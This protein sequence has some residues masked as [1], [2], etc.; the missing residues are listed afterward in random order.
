[1]N[2]AALQFYTFQI[3]W[4]FAHPK[5]RVLIIA[6]RLVKKVVKGKKRPLPSIDLTLHL[7]PRKIWIYWAQGWDSAPQLVI[8]CRDSW[9]ARNPGWE[10]VEIDKDTV[11]NHCTVPSVLTEKKIPH[12]WQSDIIRLHLLSQQ[13]GVWA[14]ATTFCTQSLD[15][16]LPGVTQSGFFAFDKPKTTLASWFLVS[17][18]QHLL[19]VKW[20]QFA[21]VYWRYLKHQRR[22]WIF[23]LFEYL[24]L[25][26]P[27]VRAIWFSTPYINSDGA[28]TVQ[29]LLKAEIKPIED[30]VGLL[31]K[32]I[33]PVH[34]LD[35]KME[36]PDTF[37]NILTLNI[38]NLE[39]ED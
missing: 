28:Y 14:D 11:I 17:R 25:F 38:Q 9:I 2:I 20:Q 15:E 37:L 30:C 31:T 24:I 22:Y 8:L 35:W 19:V 39:K 34:K 6:R 5:I 26:N 7:I 3:F 27:Q 36:I 21:D 33:S 4:F 10:I 18:K 32:D 16:W 29:H 1:M 23:F 12:V 13:G